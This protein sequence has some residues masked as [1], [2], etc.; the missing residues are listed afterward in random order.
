M[1]VAKLP[2]SK[3]S[4]YV[5]AAHGEH[6]LMRVRYPALQVQLLA[7]VLLAGE[8]LNGLHGAHVVLL[9]LKVPG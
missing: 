8:E 9:N 3:T 7:L 4:M 2:T 5:P 1:F 6:V